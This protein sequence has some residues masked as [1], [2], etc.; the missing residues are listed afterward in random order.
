MHT[1]GHTG[2][3]C[4]VLVDWLKSVEVGHPEGRMVAEVSFLGYAPITQRRLNIFTTFSNGLYSVFP[5]YGIGMICPDP[6]LARVEDS[7]ST[8]RRQSSLYHTSRN[9]CNLFCVGAF[10]VIVRPS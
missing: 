4:A 9:D 2:R 7:V 10:N 5:K 3:I 1:R 6:T 8:R